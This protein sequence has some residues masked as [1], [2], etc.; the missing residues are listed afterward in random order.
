MRIEHMMRYAPLHAASFA[1]MAFFGAVDAAEPELAN[2]EICVECLQI[3]LGPPVVVRG[4]F[5]DELDAT[6]TALKLANGSF[7]GFS[8]N[9]AT[10]AI[11]GASLWD[12][13]GARQ[14]VLQPGEP[15]SINECGR[16]LT[17][18]MRSGDEALGLVHQEGAC[19]SEEHTSELQSRPHLVCRLLLE[20]KK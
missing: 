1:V 7:R 20:K 10:Y 15:G 4:P 5:P 19:R 14:A 13:A 9:G 16:W 17:S 12:M 6:F 2:S 18:I 3:R 11:Q 8:V